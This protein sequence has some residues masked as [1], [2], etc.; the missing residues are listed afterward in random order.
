MDPEYEILDGA[1]SLSV[2]EDDAVILLKAAATFGDPVE[3]SP[4]AAREVAAQLL[5]MADRLD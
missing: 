2:N 5:A 1:V 4:D 3:L